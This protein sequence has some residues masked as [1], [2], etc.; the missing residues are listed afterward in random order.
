MAN[1]DILAAVDIGTTKI[2]VIIAEILEDD[3]KYYYKLY[4]QKKPIINRQKD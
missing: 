4:W 1:P 2:A 3:E